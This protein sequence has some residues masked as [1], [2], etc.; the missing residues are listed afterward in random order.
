MRSQKTEPDRSSA[1][2]RLVLP[3]GLPAFLQRLNVRL[4]IAL[5]LVSTVA[6][7]V[8]GLAINQI[9]PG[10]FREQANERL[11]SSAVSIILVLQETADT[12][13]AERPTDLFVPEIRNVEVFGNVSRSATRLLVPATITIINERGQQLARATPPNPNRLEAAGQRLDPEVPAFR[14]GP[15]ALFLDEAHTVGVQYEIILSD[16]YTTREATLA[17]IRA[18]LI[19]AGVIAL[20]GSVLV[21]VVVANRFTGPISALRRVAGRVSRGE[22]DE[23]A[24]ASGVLEIDELASQFNVMADRLAGTLRELEADR[25]RLREF[26]ADVSHELRTPIAALRMY[27]ELQ[28]EGSVDDATRAEFLERAAE[29]IRRLEWMSTN[30][31]DLSRIDAGIFPLDVRSG[32]LRDPIRA[33]VEAHA[34]VA[35]ERGISLASRVPVHGVEAQFDRERIVQLLNNL[36]ENALKFTQRGGEVV[37]HLEENRDGA[38]IEVRDTGPGIP[39]DELPRIF[40]RFYRGTNIGEARASGSGLGLAIVRSIV[41]MHGGTIDVASVMGEGTVFRIILFRAAG[42]RAQPSGTEPAVVPGRAAQA[43]VGAQ[44][45]S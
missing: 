5:A 45:G 8:S 26:V 25:D 13:R 27:N 2:R 11:E 16:P 37:L 20:I 17:Q 42:A 30:L 31:L 44:E 21:G 29:Q 15:Q 39:P 35:E 19:G 38:T 12:L 3:R 34:G 36:V 4:V 14:S 23:R 10:Y 43:A 24:T 6:L 9:L 41:E 28:R 33:V 22:L 1:S 7:T 40:E 18:T 32:D